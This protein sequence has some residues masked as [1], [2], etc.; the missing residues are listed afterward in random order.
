MCVCV[1]RMNLESIQSETN[2]V[3]KRLKNCEMKVSSS[4]EDLKDQYLSALQ[5]QQSSPDCAPCRTGSAS[6]DSLTH[7]MSRLFC[8]RIIYLSSSS[9]VVFSGEPA[10]V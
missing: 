1:C 6:Q 7:N 4:S 9:S 3:I 5:V 10:G 2:S 8:G